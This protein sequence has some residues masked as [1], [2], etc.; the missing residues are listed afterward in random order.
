MRV[1]NSLWLVNGT[2]APSDAYDATSSREGGVSSGNM[3]S[4]KL[5]HNHH[6]GRATLSARCMIGL[7]LSDLP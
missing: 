5:D 2:L 1:P 3:I 7:F 6:P 4:G